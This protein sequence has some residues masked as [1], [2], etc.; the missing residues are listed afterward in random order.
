MGIRRAPHQTTASQAPLVAFDFD[1]TLTVRDS[2]AAFLLWD[3]GPLRAALALARL[4]PAAL[5]YLVD[6]DRGAMKAAA[7]RA[8][9]RGRTLEHA[10]A[11]AEAFA[12]GAGLLRPDAL[13][14]WEAWGERGARRVIVTASPEFIVAPFARWLGADDLIATRLEIDGAGRITGA[15]IGRNC[16][17][18]EKVERLRAAYGPDVRLAAAYGDSAGDREMLA[19]ADEAGLKVFTGRP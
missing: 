12:H 19:L 10:Q 1:G 16:R 15:L 4:A 2:F 5:R 7:A 18:P 13:A 9:L 14:C 8:F 17:G 3:S 6:R 11:V